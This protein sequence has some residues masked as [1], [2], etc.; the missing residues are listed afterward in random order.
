[1]QR[2]ALS[3]GLEA[4]MDEAGVAEPPDAYF[5]EEYDQGTT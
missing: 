1:L 3:T 5:L 4:A 2:V